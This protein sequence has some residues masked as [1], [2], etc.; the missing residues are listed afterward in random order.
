M[1]TTWKLWTS[2]VSIFQLLTSLPSLHSFGIHLDSWWATL[3]ILLPFHTR[4]HWWMWWNLWWW[5]PRLLTKDESWSIERIHN[6]YRIQVNWKMPKRAESYH[7]TQLPTCVKI[8]DSELCFYLSFHFILFLF[9]FSFI[10][11]F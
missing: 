9:L 4:R 3:T 10:F 2:G 8:V 1:K 11:Y 5:T 6:R 7:H